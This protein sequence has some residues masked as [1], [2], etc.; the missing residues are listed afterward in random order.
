MT[1][2]SMINLNKVFA[3]IEENLVEY[4]KSI[5]ITW[6]L[7]NSEIYELLTG[8][9]KPDFDQ[10]IT[11]GQPGNSCLFL[12]FNYTNTLSLYEKEITKNLNNSIINIHGSLLRKDNPIIFGYGD[13]MD[14][15][16][17]N[18][19][20][21]NNNEFLKHIKSFSYFKTDN[22]KRFINFV[23]DSEFIVYI[24]GLS[25]GISD[26]ILL[27]SIFE[28]KNCQSI[29]I[30][31]HHR[32]ENDTDFFEKTQEISRHFKPQNKELMRKLIVPFPDC[33]PLTP[34]IPNK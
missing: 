18:I 5:N 27:N 22:Y 26:R 34:L 32:G 23:E 29:Q 11:K 13:E 1:I 24:L 30:F 31:Y 16:Y 17:A 12:N 3:V 6:A 20:N 19:E 14:P 21:L 4:L 10:V 15:Y 33:S 9:V 8:I 25:C 2:S 7:Q 28:N